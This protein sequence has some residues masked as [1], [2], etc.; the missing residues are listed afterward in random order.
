MPV[1]LRLGIG[2]FRATG[3]RRWCKW[4][5]AWYHGGCTV[6]WI[7]FHSYFRKQND[8]SA[9]AIIYWSCLY[10]GYT[11]IDW[12]CLLSCCVVTNQINSDSMRFEWVTLLYGYIMLYQTPQTRVTITEL[13]GNGVLGRLI[14]RAVS[15]KYEL[16][17]LIIPRT[18]PGYWW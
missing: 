6:I 8:C 12:D 16:I 5:Q 4:V 2:G 15:S 10:L 1:L 13:R 9:S 18:P 3:W 11:I 7:C 14:C 17:Q